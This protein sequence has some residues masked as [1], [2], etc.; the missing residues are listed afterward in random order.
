LALGLD[1]H[2]YG[3]TLDSPEDYGDSTVFR[4]TTNGALT[5]LDSF[6]GA[7]GRWP[8]SGLVWGPDGHLYGTT[9]FGGNQDAGTVFRITANGLLTRLVSFPFNGYVSPVAALLLGEDGNFYGTQ[10]I[11]L[12]SK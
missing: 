7:N 11:G 12:Y 4:V 3:T 2:F 6:T 9:S 1:R 8:Q 5:T 10:H